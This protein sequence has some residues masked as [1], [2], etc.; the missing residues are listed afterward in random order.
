MDFNGPCYVLTHQRVWLSTQ[1][2]AL[3]CRIILLI[4][5]L[6]CV[7]PQ[8]AAQV[9][10]NAIWKDGQSLKKTEDVR[11]RHDNWVEEGI[12][13]DMV[14]K[15]F[16]QLTSPSGLVYIELTA[17]NGSVFKGSDKFS[18]ML[19]PPQDKDVVINVFSGN[20]DMQSAGGGVMTSGEVGLVVVKTEYSVRVR[21]TE[22]GPVREFLTFEG[23]VQIDPPVLTPARNEN[24]TFFEAFRQ[25][26]TTGD[27]LVLEKN[28]VTAKGKIQPEDIT[29]SATVYAR[30]DAAK[31]ARQRNVN[32]QETFET[33]VRRYTAVFEDPKNAEK[34][35]ALAID[36]VNL[37]VND[38]AV[39]QLRKAERLTPVEQKKTHALI[40]LAKAIAFSQ[41]GNPVAAQVEVQKARDLDPSILEGPSLGAFRFNDKTRQ[42]VLQFKFTPVSPGVDPV[43]LRAWPVPGKMSPDQAEIFRL[44]TEGKFAAASQLSGVTSVD[45]PLSSVDA[46]AY[47]IIYYAL[48]DTQNARQAAAY[49]LKVSL[50]DKLL[51]KEAQNAAQRILRLARQQ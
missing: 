20:G 50:T 16:D 31:A 36:Q 29:K 8:A 45:K 14:L 10:V 21:H 26:L 44:I 41:A 37:E 22:A 49:A 47:A 12:Q 13:L 18:I 39:Y 7:V 32:P 6:L 42:Q 1:P 9:R 15:P 40:A 2:G 43:T 27:K 46:Y 4:A 19:L 51:S 33:L 11:C 34:R 28:V 24:L 23:E 3:V 5:S 30:L 38:D 48:Q 25:T 35:I 17:P